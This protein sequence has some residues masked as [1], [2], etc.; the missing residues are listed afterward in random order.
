VIGARAAISEAN[1]R[2]GG[3]AFAACHEPESERLVTVD[4]PARHEQVC[5]LL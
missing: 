4:V 1:E 2:F 3:V 5:A